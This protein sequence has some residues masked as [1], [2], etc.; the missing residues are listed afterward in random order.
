MTTN[1]SMQTAQKNKMPKGKSR[2]HFVF[3]KV[4][5]NANVKVMQQ[6]D[7]NIC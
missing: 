2:Q 7:E 5:A 6:K 4:K 3:N 1:K